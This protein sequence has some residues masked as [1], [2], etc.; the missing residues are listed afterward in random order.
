MLRYFSHLQ[1]EIKNKASE[2]RFQFL[3]GFE[4]KWRANR[5]NFLFPQKNLTF[6]LG[7]SEE[8]SLT[9]ETLLRFNRKSQSKAKDLNVNSN[10][11]HQIP[12]SP[13]D[14][15]LHFIG[16]SLQQKKDFLS[17]FVLFSS[18]NI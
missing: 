13:N 15:N 6:V 11:T 7:F 16:Y 4:I 9:S 10:T 1:S 14:P 17:I 12:E 18:K 3:D 2:R 8:I 5:V